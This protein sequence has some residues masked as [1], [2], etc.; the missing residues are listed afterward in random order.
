VKPNSV[1]LVVED[2]EESRETLRELLEL[3]GYSVDTAANGKQALE[4]LEKIAPCV[5]LLDLFMPVLDGWKVIEQLRSSGR[6]ATLKIII[7]TSAP[8]TAP[9]GLTVLAKPLDLDKLS[10]AVAAAC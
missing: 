4:K 8:S 7:I 10:R 9:E 1:V 6:L 2:D 3:D 5:I